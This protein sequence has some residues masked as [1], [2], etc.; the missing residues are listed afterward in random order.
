MK[1]RR[2]IVV[3]ACAIVVATMV[4]RNNWSDLAYVQMDREEIAE[5]LGLDEPSGWDMLEVHRKRAS[6][7][8]GLKYWAPD[9]NCYHCYCDIPEYPAASHEHTH[10]IGDVRLLHAVLQMHNHGESDDWFNKLD[11]ENAPR[12]ICQQCF[13]GRKARQRRSAE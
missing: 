5:L 12:C 2:T 11:V 4:I 10:E 7:L 8:P 9:Q 6:W 3:M 13:P 1:K